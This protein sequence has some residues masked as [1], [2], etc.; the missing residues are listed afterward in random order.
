[1][2]TISIVIDC[3]KKTC[4]H[5]QF[6][7]TV[8]GSRIC[9]AFDEQRDYNPKTGMLYRLRQCLAGG[10]KDPCKICAGI[11][12]LNYQDV[13]RIPGGTEKTGLFEMKTL[14]GYDDQNSK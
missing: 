12:E 7:G 9:S 4:G 8:D 1:M 2:K 5:C 6:C 3:N 10:I 13:A 14:G 11:E